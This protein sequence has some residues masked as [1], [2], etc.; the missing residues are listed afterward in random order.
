MIE[1]AWPWPCVVA[2]ALPLLAL[3]VVVV[4]VTGLVAELV[5]VVVFVVLE[6]AGKPPAGAA[7]LTRYWPGVCGRREGG[8][9]GRFMA[10]DG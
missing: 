7:M 6:V 9:T 8:W 3:V 10:D 2:A 5:V 1:A 4:L